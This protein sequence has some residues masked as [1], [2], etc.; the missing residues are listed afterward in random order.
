MLAF[1]REVR[2]DVPTFEEAM[3][4]TLA[5]VLIS[6][7]FLYLVESSA[8]SRRKLNDH[9]LASRLSYFLWSTMPD[10]RLFKLADEGSLRDS[11]VLA[12]EVQRLLAD[13]RF[14]RSTLPALPRCGH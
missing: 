9:E 3:R 11:K 14:F 1:F 4:E 5:M 13:P 7:D 2:A 8:G 6:P 10:E 12:T